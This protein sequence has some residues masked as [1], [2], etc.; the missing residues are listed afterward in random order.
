MT[1]RD[2][3]PLPPFDIKPPTFHHYSLFPPT[4]FSRIWRIML[5]TTLL[6]ALPATFILTATV[7]GLPTNHLVERATIDD[8]INVQRQRSMTGVRDNLGPVGAKA[9]GAPGGILVASP[10]RSDPNCTRPSSC[11]V[12]LPH[13]F[14]QL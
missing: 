13:Y 11:P 4:P 9:P 12:I 5:L 7:H 3:E 10:S 1:H 2:V 14:L 6:F 8:F